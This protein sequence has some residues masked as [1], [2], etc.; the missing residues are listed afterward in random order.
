MLPG[1]YAAFTSCRKCC[2]P[3]YDIYFHLFW[4]MAYLYKAY[5][6][7]VIKEE[8]HRRVFCSVVGWDTGLVENTTC[9]LFFTLDC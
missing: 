1:P 4:L 2:V 9:F 3:H 6:F 5:I 7:C 8:A